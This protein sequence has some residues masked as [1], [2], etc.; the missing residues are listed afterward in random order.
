MKTTILLLGT[1]SII[2]AT[3]GA[4]YLKKAAKTITL[5]K[6]INLNLIKSGTAYVLSLIPFVTALKTTD[7]SLLYPFTSFYYATTSIAGT[8]IFKE[9]ITKKKITGII[10]ITAGIILTG[11]GK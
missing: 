6:P 10:L 7:L 8:I 2:L 4:I 1:A 5:K 3:I 9:K 11:I